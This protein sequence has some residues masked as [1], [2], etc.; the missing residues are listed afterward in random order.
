M[1]KTI[2]NCCINRLLKNLKRKRKIS[3]RVVTIKMVGRDGMTET[4]RDGMTGVKEIGETEERTTTT[5][6]GAAI[7]PRNQRNE[8]PDLLLYVHVTSFNVYSGTPL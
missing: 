2:Y 8:R 3:H 6:E 4:R 1:K 7:D 5:R